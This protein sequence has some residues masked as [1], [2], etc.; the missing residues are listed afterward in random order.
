MSRISIEIVP[1]TEAELNE[2]L[3]TTFEKFPVFDTINIPDLLRFDI[4]SWQGC[5]IAKKYS[6]NTIPH[7]RSID[8][9]MY[10]PLPMAQELIEN[11]INEVLILTGDPPQDYSRKIYPTTCLDVIQKF[12]KE[13]PH[14]KVYAAIDQY[15]HGM[16]R[17]LEYIK[18]KLYAGAEGFFTQPFFDLRLLDIYAEMLENVEV[19]WGVSPILSEKSISYWEAK[20]HVVFPKNFEPNL[21]WNVKLA[22]QI[23]NYSKEKNAN[24]YFMPIRTN[25]EKYF[26]G[27]FE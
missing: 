16:R 14:I 9:N 15:R 18:R 27:I 3:T 21:E 7:I 26:K 2:E 8:I 11:D 5:K 6:K 25:S 24:L 13:L 10:E 17:E 19:F 20:N 1:R 4:R 12:K 22:K 23:L